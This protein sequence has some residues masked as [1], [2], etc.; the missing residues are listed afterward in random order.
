MT[1]QTAQVDHA[2]TPPRHDHDSGN[3]YIERP[4]WTCGACRRVWRWWNGGYGGSLFWWVEVQGPVDESG[5]DD[6]ESV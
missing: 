6:G 5:A 4:A 1:D 3:Y 2:C